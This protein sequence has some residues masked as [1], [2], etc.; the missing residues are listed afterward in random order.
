M[1]LKSIFLLA[2]LFIVVLSS[3]VFDN[4]RAEEYESSLN[5][6]REFANPQRRT[7]KVVQIF[8]SEDTNHSGAVVSFSRKITFFD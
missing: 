4:S 2:I 6:V 7:S 1:Q 3:L 8:P 5:N